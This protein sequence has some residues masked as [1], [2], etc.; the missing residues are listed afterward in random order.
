MIPPLAG[1]SVRP[2][3]ALRQFAQRGPVEYCNLCNV[4]VGQT[5]AHLI[6]P[7][8]RRILCACPSCSALFGG[9]YKRI[10]R[11]VR[12]LEQFK[13]TDNQWDNLAVPINMAFFFHSTVGT[14]VVGLYPSPAGAIESAM[15]PDRW[16]EIAE[17]HPVLSEMEPDVEALLVNRLGP[18]KGHDGPGYY[19]LPI[20][21]CFRL[22][23]LVRVHWRGL[24][25]GTEVWREIGQFF[26][27]MKE[28]SCRV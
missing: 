27:Q 14:Q 7:A 24:S 15:P 10:P 11:R 23:G 4:R 9:K 17:N 18:A 26:S 16:R 13:L 25:G 12:F 5:H 3:Q 8:N 20:D 2:F 19:I 28:R 22:V 6:D 21:E 1:Q